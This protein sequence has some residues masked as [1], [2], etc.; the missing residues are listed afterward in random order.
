[1]RLGLVRDAAALTWRYDRHPL[2]RYRLTGWQVPGGGLAA[3]AVTARRK[4]FGLDCTLVA[5]VIADPDA[6]ARVAA[7]TLRAAF[8]GGQGAM[9]VAQVAPGQEGLF[10]AAGFLPVPARLDPKR[11]T[12]TMLPICVP[13]PAPGTWTFGWG[14]MDVV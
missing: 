13:L 1:M 3:L 9:A 2:H 5:D 10:R 7:T 8:S 12:L 14:D 11:F 6:G 4:L